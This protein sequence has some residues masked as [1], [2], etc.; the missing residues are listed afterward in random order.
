MSSTI[1]HPYK[2]QILRWLDT[3]VNL[4]SSMFFHSLVLQFIFVVVVEET[5]VSFKSPQSRFADYDSVVSINR[6]FYP[7]YF[8]KFKS[9]IWKLYK[10]QVCLFLGKTTSWVVLTSFH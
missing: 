7:L 8:L 1:S 10:I 6:F 9:Y 2:V 5:K 4:L 3:I